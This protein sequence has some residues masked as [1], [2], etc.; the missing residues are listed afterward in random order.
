[1]TRTWIQ[2]SVLLYFICIQTG[3]RSSYI[4]SFVF[5]KFFFNI[6]ILLLFFLLLQ[7]YYENRLKTLS[8]LKAA[9]LNPYP[10]KFHVSISIAEY[11]DKYGSLSDGAHLEDVEVSISGNYILVLCLNVLISVIPF[12]AF[13]FLCALV[14]SQL[15]T[16]II[17]IVQ[18]GL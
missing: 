5:I 12:S 2:Q 7:Q 17:C 14:I 11:I 16:I 9:G 10:H 1:M 4:S 6:E 15:L 18:V 8:S 13:S 3:F